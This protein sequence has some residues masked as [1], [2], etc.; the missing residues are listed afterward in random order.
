MGEKEKR[1]EGEFTFPYSPIP[2]FSTRRS[3]KF[4]NM[5]SDVINHPFA[6]RFH[7]ILK[8]LYKLHFFLTLAA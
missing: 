6:T 2:P 1:K 4:H 7:V 8:T 3:D 5:A